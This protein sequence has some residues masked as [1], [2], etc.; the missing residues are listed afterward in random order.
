MPYCF[1]ADSAGWGFFY[2]SLENRCFIVG[3]A[4]TL[5]FQ[6]FDVQ[7]MRLQVV[8]RL[9]VRHKKGAFAPAEPLLVLWTCFTIARR[10]TRS[11]LIIFLRRYQ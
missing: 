3:W 8:V 4:S 6:R 10:F 7:R 2:L 9:Y 1:S 5:L 11:E